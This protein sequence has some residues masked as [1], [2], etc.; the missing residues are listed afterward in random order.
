MS[1]EIS[2]YLFLMSYLMKGRKLEGKSNSMQEM[3]YREEAKNGLKFR[4]LYGSLQDVFVPQMYLEQSSRKVL[5][6][7]WVEGKKLSAVKDIYLIE[8]GVYCSLTQLLEYGFYHAD[9]HPGNLLRTTDG[10]LA[11]LGMTIFT[12]VLY[13][14]NV[15]D[16]YDIMVD[17]VPRICVAIENAIICDEMRQNAMHLRPDA[18]KENAGG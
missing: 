6:M 7:E 17:E 11:Y 2:I 4:E 10:K 14:A 5:I 3:D 15:V 1:Y 13:I 18:F 9:P 16:Q 8:V 12:S